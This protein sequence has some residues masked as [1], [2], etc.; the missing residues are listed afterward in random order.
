MYAESTIRVQFS[1]VSKQFSQKPDHPKTMCVQF[2]DIQS[3]QA[4]RK[5]HPSWMFCFL[6]SNSQYRVAKTWQPWQCVDFSRTVFFLGKATILLICP[7]YV[8]ENSVWKCILLEWVFTYTLIQIQV[9]EL[10][11]C[12]CICIWLGHRW[13]SVKAPAAPD[14]SVQVEL[15]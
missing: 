3:Q 9:L 5:H 2:F 11:L 6:W 1:L 4:I 15:H 12:I 13:G 8:A 7:K 10:C 14:Q